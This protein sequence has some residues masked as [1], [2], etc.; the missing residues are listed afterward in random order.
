MG[1]HDPDDPVELL[2]SQLPGLGQPP[3]LGDDNQATK[4]PITVGIQI[5][6]SQF[7]MKYL[8]HSQGFLTG[9]TNKILM[10][11][12]KGSHHRQ[13]AILVPDDKLDCFAL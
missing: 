1:A 13:M 6:P 2:V 7:I 10:D 4:E 11:Q 12:A 5:T 8:R 9:H 3:V